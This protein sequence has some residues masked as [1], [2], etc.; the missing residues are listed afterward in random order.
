MIHSILHFIFNV[1]I[2]MMNM[3]ILICLINVLVYDFSKFEMIGFLYKNWSYNLIKK[4]KIEYQTSSQNSINEF[5]PLINIS[6]PGI[7]QGC[8]C[9]LYNNKLYMG[10]CSTNLLNKNCYDVEPIEPD[11]LNN[12]YLPEINTISNNGIII[13]IERYSNLSYLDLINNTETNENYFISNGN[14]CN[15]DKNSKICVDCGIID[16]LGNHLCITSYEGINNNCYKIKLEYDYSLK[17]IKLI[18][19]LE[20]IFSNNNKNISY[21]Q[22]PIE[23][24]TLYD[25]NTACILQDESISYPNIKYELILS[26]NITTLFNPGL[27]NKGCISEIFHKIT[28]DYRWNNFISFPMEYIFESN[29]KKELYQLPRFPYDDIINKNLSLNYRS[30]IGFRNRCINNINF[31]K[32]NIIPYEK[33]VKIRFLLLL[34]TAMIFFPSFLLFFMMISQIDIISFYQR[35]FFSFAFTL[36]ILGFLQSIYFELIDMNEK[37]ENI[38]NIANNY[39]GDNLTNNLFFC[40]LNDFKNLEN[41]TKYCCYWTGIM[42]ITSFCKIILILTKAYKRRILYYLYSNNVNISTRIEMQLLI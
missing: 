18:K 16:S 27:K 25:N 8:D 17:D 10:K 26:D 13:Y 41:T 29:I 4:I 7:L 22:Y 28:K 34:F 2:V 20:L 9:T 19:D 36:S 40:I 31:I 35:L 15:C 11:Y 23:F 3:S 6:F 1:I 38:R 39:C 5:E 37:Y 32:E 12:L 24:M 42:L 14:N 21:L 33:L 30:F